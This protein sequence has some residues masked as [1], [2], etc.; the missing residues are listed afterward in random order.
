MYFVGIN[1]GAQVAIILLACGL[2]VVVVN[3]LGQVVPWVE[4]PIQRRPCSIFCEGYRVTQHPRVFH[5]LTGCQRDPWF[6]G[7]T[8]I[9]RFI[10][11]HILHLNY[12]KF[13]INLQNTLNI[14]KTTK[15][16]FGVLHDPS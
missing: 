1:A 8:L 10:R 13:K 12:E 15:V 3:F 9:S 16:Y 5:E 6:W 7:V 11:F 4:L 14:P 2:G